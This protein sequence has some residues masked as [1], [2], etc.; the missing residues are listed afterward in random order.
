MKND[1]ET[2]ANCVDHWQMPLNGSKTT[3]IG[4]IPQ[5]LNNYFKLNYY[6]ITRVVGHMTLEIWWS[7]EISNTLVF[8][9]PCTFV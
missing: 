5:L 4:F 7:S 9:Y 3:H 2:V 1:V 8:L 6:A